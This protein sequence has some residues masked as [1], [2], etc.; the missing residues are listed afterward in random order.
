MK[1]IATRYEMLH[2]RLKDLLEVSTNNKNIE[3]AKIRAEFYENTIVDNLAI[4]E[5][6]K[7]GYLE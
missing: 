3:I 7:R 1:K 2:N 4:L 5:Q 6:I